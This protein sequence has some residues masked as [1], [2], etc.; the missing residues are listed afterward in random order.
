MDV[1]E[2][3]NCGDER[4]EF[5][6]SVFL[7]LGEE[8]SQDI[9]DQFIKVSTDRLIEEFG[10]NIPNGYDAVESM[11]LRLFHNYLGNSVLPFCSS[12][13]VVEYINNGCVPLWEV[14]EG[15]EDE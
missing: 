6:D 14:N 8:R 15:D 13:C 4:E 1:Y 10:D 5:P 11:T 2:C 7:Y 9:W 12:S 3:S